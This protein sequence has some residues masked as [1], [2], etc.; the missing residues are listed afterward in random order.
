MK[1]IIIY[2]YLA[3]YRQPIFTELMKSDK[4]EFTLYSGNTSDIEIKKIE[5]DYSLKEINDGGLRWF[6]FKNR[7]FLKNKILWQSGLINLAINGDYDCI[8]FLGSPYHISTWFAS[9]IGRIRSKKVFYWMHGVYKD[10]IAFVDYVKLF[11]FYKIA[12]GFFLYGK[13]AYNILSKYYNEENIHIVYNSLD[14]KKSIE[15]RKTI[16]EKDIYNYRV[17]YFNDMSTPVVVFI[18]RLNHIKRLDLLI[19]AQNNL[20]IKYKKN[21]F[22]V[23]IIGDG[24]EKHNLEN[25]V[26]K[27]GLQRNVSFLGA[28]Y[29]ENINSN[30]LSHADLCVTPGEVGL[31][32][33]HSLSYGT[34]VISHDNLNIQMPEVESIKRGITGDLYEY[35]NL[36]DLARS[37]EEWFLSRP[38]KNQTI[39]ED[40][41]AIIDEYYNPNYQLKVFESVLFNAN[42]L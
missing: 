28:I 2:H 1:T 39:I 24:E 13:R 20:K 15:F 25:L 16:A 14:Y 4:I 36:E 8:V 22:N 31:T 26:S 30:I 17:T 18:G 35:N 6:F 32:A 11:V 10:K 19:E 21:V 5:T 23:L 12:N 7:W 3:S 27:R 41:Y 38:I 37:I 34:P 9:V 42:N 33:I 29:D 40:C